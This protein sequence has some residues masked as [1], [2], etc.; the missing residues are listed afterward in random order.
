MVRKHERVNQRTGQNGRY[1]GRPRLICYHAV[2]TKH[3]GKLH[4]TKSFRQSKL[5]QFLYPNYSYQKNR[6]V[7]VLLTL[8][9]TECLL[10]AKQ[11]HY[12][13]DFIQ[14]S[15]ILNSLQYIY[16]KGKKRE[17]WDSF[18]REMVKSNCK[19]KEF[20]QRNIEGLERWLMVKDTYHSSRELIPITCNSS[21]GKRQQLWHLPAPALTCTHTHTPDTYTFI[22]KS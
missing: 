15:Y 7:M 11:L 17:I 19:E 14:P 3:C 12:M 22:F 5:L 18:L 9:L 2:Y 20:Y 21:S 16:H 10:D 4:Y 8:V 13:Y 1:W 6:A